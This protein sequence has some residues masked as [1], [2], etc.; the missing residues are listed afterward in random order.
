MFTCVERELGEGGRA[1]VFLADDLK[2]E[3]VRDQSTV[4]SPTGARGEWPW[5]DEATE[6]AF[7]D[8]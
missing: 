2:H 5:L 6:E 1:T 7:R 4:D 8:A 3:R